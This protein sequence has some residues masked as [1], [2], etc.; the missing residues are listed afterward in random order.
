MI[1]VLRSES[2]E[3]EAVVADGGG[4][5]FVCGSLFDN[6]A[7]S[8][9]RTPCCKHLVCGACVEEVLSTVGPDKTCSACA[10]QLS[11]IHASIASF[12]MDLAVAC[13]RTRAAVKAE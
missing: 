6:T 12:P 7:H 10:V 8:P 2:G 3:P 11:A 4:R 5:C 1:P 13:M 9:R